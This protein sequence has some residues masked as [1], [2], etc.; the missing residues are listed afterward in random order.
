MLSQ[1][2]RPAARVIGRVRFPSKPRVYNARFQSSSSGSTSSG[3]NSALIGGVAGG[4]FAAAAGYTW[5]S[6]S[7]AK[8]LVDTNKQAKQYLEQAKQKI[9]EAAP[10]PNESYAWF[11]K[12]VTRYAVFIPGAREYVDTAFKDLEKI[13][14]KHDEEFDKIIQD[15]YKDL[16]EVSKKG[17]FDTNTA[18]EAFYVLQKHLD[19]LLDL[20]GDVG[21]DILDNHPKVKEKLGGSFDQLKQMGDAYGPQAKEEVTKTWSQI[22]DIIKRGASIDAVAEIKKLIDEKKEKLQ[23]LGEEAWQ[24]GLDE[25]RQFMEK[26]PKLKSLVEENAD[27]LKKGNFQDLW[28]LLKDSASSGKTEEVEKY[29]K[30]RVDQVKSGGFGDLD[31]WLKAIPGGS[32]ILPQ[33]QTLQTVA[34]KKG[35]DAEKV[36]KETFEEIQD[37]LKKRKEQVEKIAEEAKEETK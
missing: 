34:Q 30:E 28:G 32:N 27:A 4:A 11:K 23:K 13:K 5:Y 15:A 21:E 24:K 14:E 19:R 37:V 8:T 31:K 29:V 25:S 20:A 7:G 1:T 3:A 12:T 17:G 2:Q 36:L 18:F 10:G 33:L 35:G 26:N 9:S 16:S 22:T 6:F